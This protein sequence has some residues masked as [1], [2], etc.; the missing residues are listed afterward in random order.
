MA[1]GD[2]GTDEGGRSRGHAHIYLYIDDEWIQQ[3]PNGK[4][5]S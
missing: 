1:M 2:H 3:G 5:T 4:T